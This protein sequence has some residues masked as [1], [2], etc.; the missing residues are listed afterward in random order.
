M[1]FTYVDLIA[2]SESL[3]DWQ[4]DALRRVL[5]QDQISEHDL[6]ELVSLAKA[7]FAN[8]AST[9]LVS[10]P[11]STEHVQPP[12]EDLTTVSLV[13]IRD[14]ARVNAL[15]VGPIPFGIEGLTIVYGGNATGKSGIARILKRACQS[16]DS[17]GLVRSNVFEP[18]TNEPAAATIDFKVG[19]NQ[20]S[21]IW[22]DG[23]TSDADLRTV[24]VFDARSAAVQ[25]AQPNLISYTPQI[26]QT[27]K[28]LADVTDSV[29]ETLRQEKQLLGEKPNALNE[30][31][32]DSNTAAGTFMAN[33]SAVSDKDLLEKLC[34]ISEGE[35][36]R[37]EELQ[38]ALEDDPLLKLQ[39]EQVRN[40]TIAQLDAVIAS[41]Q[42]HLSDEACSNL[43]RLLQEQSATQQ[44]AEAARITFSSNSV[45]DGLGTAAWRILLDSAKRYSEKHAYLHEAFPVVRKGSVCVLCQQPL[46]L[47]ASAR[48][49]SFEDFVRTDVQ[50]NAEDAKAKVKDAEESL[51]L[52]ALPDS[53]RTIRIQIGLTDG[54]AGRAVRLFLI[55]A[56]L[57]RRHLLHMCS[58]QHK[59]LCPPL[60]RQP[61]LTALAKATRDEIA[62]L[63]AASQAGER[64]TMESECLEIQTRMKLSPHLGTV[65]AE[66]DR[67]ASVSRL[68]RALGDCKTHYITL[69]ARQ[70]A[71]EV[72][73]ERLRSSFIANLSAIGFEETPVEVTLGAGEH[74]KH[75]YE[76]KLIPRP[77]VPPQDVLSEGERTCV[78]LAGFLAE[79]ETTGNHSAIVLDDPVSSLDHR[80]RK[81]VAERLVREAK[82]R[83][84]IVLTHDIV[85]LF[86]LRKY[87]S[88][89]HATYEEVSLERG[90]KRNH[91][92]AT[93]GPPWVAM[94]VRQ[95]I[96]ALRNDLVEARKVL[97]SG[98]RATYERWASEIY[99]RLRQT[100]ER[101]VEEVLL[102]ETVMRFG[103]SVQTQRLA[104]LVDISETDVEIVTKEM[105]RCSDFV[106]D[107]AGPINADLPA[108]DTIESDIKRL[109]D[110]V[111]ELRKNRG[112][113]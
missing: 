49:Q 103:D 72:I 48:L 56:K 77:Q 71:K 17:G 81:R 79:L 29:A 109:D 1:P 95:R 32:L 107:E 59:G 83:Q 15:C 51:R 85:F 84:V 101:A 113:N 30:L 16:R 87:S 111:K 25:V 31:Y 22:I 4:R 43:E 58:G 28:S 112:R 10:I 12:S 37:L 68:D 8:G 110:W 44:A 53:T 36:R 102:Y 55:R 42:L 108:P 23:N 92:R 75:P 76:M 90:Y 104:R 9:K 88:E 47:E 62:R 5:G 34:S 39:L 98:D 97:T 24:N 21:H 70:A 33:L 60:P 2:W 6:I 93:T 20:R 57:R 41:V 45:L 52:L 65:K 78:A 99:K 38:R 13:A 96:A 66:I 74:G 82:S 19:Q 3:P 69:K 50:Q 35:K 105:S 89:L 27:L 80:Y 40:K 14:I 18:D 63:R 100:W 64:L 61:E 73:T 94:P 91:G 67:L 106:H 11:A 7:P 46:S 86:L 54:E 26:L